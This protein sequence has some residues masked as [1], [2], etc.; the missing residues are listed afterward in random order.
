MKKWVCAVMAML[1]L[2][3]C[4]PNFGELVQIPA[5]DAPVE[6]G[7][8]VA[9][10]L[11]LQKEKI[12]QIN[13]VRL[14][15]LQELTPGDQTDFGR[16]TVENVVRHEPACLNQRLCVRQYQNPSDASASHI[17]ENEKIN[18]YWHARVDSGISLSAGEVQQALGF[19]VEGLV[20]GPGDVQVELQPGENVEV[21]II[22]I[23]ERYTFEVYKET[24]LGEKKQVGEGCAYRIVGY[25]TFV[26]EY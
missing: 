24:L 11:G 22:P 23:C 8:Q 26:C 12:R 6:N 4:T 18:Q 15:D 17:L 20:E 1:L 19:D 13:Y 5:I 16:I 7:E 3:G 10:A 14:D 25:Y 21:I 2:C 9:A